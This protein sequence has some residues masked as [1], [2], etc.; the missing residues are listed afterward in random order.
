MRISYNKA[1]KEKMEGNGN[2]MSR[3]NKNVFG[4]YEENLLNNYAKFLAVNVNPSKMLQKKYYRNPPSS[5]NQS[6]KEG[7]SITYNYFGTM[8]EHINN[9]TPNEK[10]SNKMKKE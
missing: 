2:Y 3:M 7:E 5:T 8:Q 1:Y 10:D 6:V 4:T 9:N